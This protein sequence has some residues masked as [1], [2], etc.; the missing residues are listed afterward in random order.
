M[1]RNEFIALGRKL[2]FGARPY[3]RMHAIAISLFALAGWPVSKYLPDA[4]VWGYIAALLIVCIGYLFWSA[5]VDRATGLLC[6]SCRYP[7]VRGA[8]KMAMDSNRCPYC[9]KA[10]FAAED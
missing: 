6:N 2:E 4:A 3:D 5:R 10:A 9:K 1:T 8:A 7:M